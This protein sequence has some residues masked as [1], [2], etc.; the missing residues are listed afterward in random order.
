[1]L[2]VNVSDFQLVSSAEGPFTFLSSIHLTRMIPFLWKFV[3]RVNLHQLFALTTC[4]FP[5]EKLF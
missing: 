5:K 4:I 1:M 2:I 3:G